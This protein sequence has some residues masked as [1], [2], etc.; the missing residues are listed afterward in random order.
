MGDIADVVFPCGWVLDE[1]KNEIRLYYGAA[2]T[3]MAVAT[4]SFKNVMSYIKS[5]P[6]VDMTYMS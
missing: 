6:K 4:A 2:D 5:C 3:V 1:K